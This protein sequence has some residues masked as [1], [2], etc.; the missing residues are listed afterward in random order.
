MGATT[1]FQE[2]WTIKIDHIREKMETDGEAKKKKWEN[3]FSAE[4]QQIKMAIKRNKGMKC[5]KLR[6]SLA[7][8][9][10]NEW[11]ECHHYEYIFRFWEVAQR[12]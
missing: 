10:L 2:Q 7:N 1:Q 5:R 3:E 6:I 8:L 9:A 12:L 4:F 11:N